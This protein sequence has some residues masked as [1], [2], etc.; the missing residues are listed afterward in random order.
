MDC[1]DFKNGDK[2]YEARF[3]PYFISITYSCFTVLLYFYAVGPTGRKLVI[4]ASLVV[5][6]SIPFLELIAD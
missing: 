2:E 4:L 3:E 6:H 1:L 5:P